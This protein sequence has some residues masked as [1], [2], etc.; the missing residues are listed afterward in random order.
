[1]QAQAAGI[2]GGITLPTE[3]FEDL[4]HQHSRLVLDVALRILGSA[5]L[6]Q[7]VHQ[8]VFLAIWRRWSGFTGHI[9]W[10]G[11]LYRAT[12][13]KAIDTAVQRRKRQPAG[14]IVPEPISS[15][16]GPDQ[17]L[18]AAELQQKLAEALARLPSARRRSSC[19]PA[20][21]GSATRQSRRCSAVRRRRLASTCI[22]P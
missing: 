22:E 13:R 9:H 6:A 17:E 15:R 11:Y 10:R 5:D 20:T 12:V 19:C 7:D 1:M 4:V 8:E 14:P 18:R 3:R 21:R 16:D 2:I